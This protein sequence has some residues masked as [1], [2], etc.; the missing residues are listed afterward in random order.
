MSKFISLLVDEG[1]LAAAKD[2]LITNKDKNPDNYGRNGIFL[3]HVP[4]EIIRDVLLF[5]LLEK[6]VE[7]AEKGKNESSGKNIKKRTSDRTRK[8]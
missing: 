5:S 6:V 8:S 7:A 3:L 2:W 1:D 4:R